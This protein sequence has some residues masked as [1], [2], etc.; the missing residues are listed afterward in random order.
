MVRW[1]RFNKVQL[2]I[3]KDKARPGIVKERA[4]TAAKTL[5]PDGYF[6][7]FSIS[8]QVSLPFLKCFSCIRMLSY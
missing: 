8:T 2:P 6:V 7:P 1:I 5:Y 3:T 4:R